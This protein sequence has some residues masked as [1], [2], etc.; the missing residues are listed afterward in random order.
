MGL[1]HGGGP[2]RQTLQRHSRRADGE[3]S[4]ET[5]PARGTGALVR[6]PKHM[7]AGTVGGED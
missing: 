5:G 7:N 2:G 4:Q 6:E 3:E 1:G